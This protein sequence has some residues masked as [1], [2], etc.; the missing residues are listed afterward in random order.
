MR[1]REQHDA[2][3]TSGPGLYFLNTINV[4]DRV[5][6]NANKHARVDL[7]F[8]VVQRVAQQVRRVGETKT[9]VV[10]LSFDGIHILGANKEDRFTILDSKALEILCAGSEL[11]QHVEDSHCVTFL[12]AV[13]KKLCLVYGLGEAF[14]IERFR[15]VID[16]V[17]IE[18]T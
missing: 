2:V 9:Y 17:D 8:D 4:D 11:L 6:M 14:S 13:H 7:R 5:S 18:G 10:A 12:C 15:Q 3:D 1:T 16:G